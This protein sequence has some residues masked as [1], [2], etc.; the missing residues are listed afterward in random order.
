M[1]AYKIVAVKVGDEWVLD[2]LGVPFNSTDSDGEY[3]TERTQ[4][5]ADRY[6]NP[7]ILYYHSYTEDGRP[8]G[9]PIAI[10]KAT[11]IERKHD[12][13]WYRVVLDKTKDYAKRIWEA[14]Q[15][16]LAEP[17]GDRGAKERVPGGDQRRPVHRLDLSDCWIGHVAVGSAVIL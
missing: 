8:Q 4:I 14:A 15:K 10:G 12:G 16:G 9:E 6:T 17:L 5:H 11:S 2:V 3:F 7:L 1:S 13:W